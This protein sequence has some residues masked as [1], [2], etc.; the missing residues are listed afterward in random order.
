MPNNIRAILTAIVV[1]IACAAFWFEHDAGETFLKW[2]AAGLGVFMVF[3]V[4][5]FPETARKSDDP[6]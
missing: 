6:D 4:W 1:L 3:A 5:L 2:L